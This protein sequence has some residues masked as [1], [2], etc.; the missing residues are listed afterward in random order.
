MFQLTAEEA[1]ILRCHIG[2]SSS[3]YGGR[4][5]LPHPFFSDLSTLRGEARAHVGALPILQGYPAPGAQ[6]RHQVSWSESLLIQPSYRTGCNRRW[7]R[8]TL[9]R[10]KVSDDYNAKYRLWAANPIVAPAGKAVRLPDFKSRRLASHAEL[11]VWK[12]SVLLQLARALPALEPSRLGQAPAALRRTARELAPVA[13][14]VTISW[15]PSKKP[16]PSASSSHPGRH[17][18]H[19]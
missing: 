3:G 4:R 2:T 12:L 15:M 17:P 13:G 11:N 10:I 7:T 18:R 19:A 8:L 16:G 1:V 14:G 6:Q 9:P 5:Y